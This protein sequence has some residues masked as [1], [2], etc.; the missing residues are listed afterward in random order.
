MQQNLTP[1]MRQY[2][3]LKEKY[4]D[5][6]LFFRLGDFYE[7]FFDDAETASREL[8]LVLTG[9]NCGLEQ[10]A[11]M[12]GVPY[13]AVD[14]YVSRLIAKGYKVAICEQ[15]TDPSLSE[16]LVVRDVIRVITP[17]TIIEESMLN[18]HKNNYIVS[19]CA[20]S[21]GVGIAYSDVSTGS[22]FVCEIAEKKWAAKLMDELSRINATE[23]IANE[24]LLKNEA[25]T[26]RIKR[27]YY[28]E[29]Y[30]APY[31]FDQKRGYD[32]LTRHFGVASLAG[33]GCESMTLAISAAGALMGYLEET[34]KN[35]LEHIKKI[36]VNRSSEYMMLDASARRNLELTQP[37]SEEYGKRST[38]LYVL[39]KTNTAM[40]SRMLRSWIDQPLQSIEKI[41]ERLDAVESLVKDPIKRKLICEL[42]DGVY[43]IERVCSRIAYGT[44]NARDCISLKL[45]T[46]LLPKIAEQ[47][48]AFDTGL[49]SQ[50]KSTLDTLQDVYELLEK[51]IND[52][53]PISVKEG[54]IIKEGYNSEIDELRYAAHG[55]RE[56]L[57]QL[58]TQERENT[59]IKNLKIGFNRVFGYYFEVTKAYQH[60]VPYYFER[61][62]TLA[63]AER[64]ITPDLKAME[65][66]ILGAE[67]KS[68]S[69]EY[70]AFLEIRKILLDDIERL[71]ATAKSVATLD[72]LASL[73]VVADSYDYCKPAMNDE[74][75]ISIENGRHPV[76]EQGM[77]GGFVPNNTYLCDDSEHRLV[78]ITG[79]NMAGKST[80][81]RQVALIVLMAH[82]G[83]FVPASNADISI[84]D[85]IFTRVGASDNVSF[86]QSTFM[87]E[88]SE[89]ANILNNATSR[90][91]LI[92]DEIGRGTSTFDGLSIAW[93]VL[94][95]IA[96]QKLLGAKT[97]FATHYHELAELEGR[98]DGVINYRMAVKEMGDDI[99]FLRKVVRGGA[100]R[101]F[102]IQVARLAGLPK[103][104]INRAKNI[105]A[106][107]EASG[108]KHEQELGI[109]AAKQLDMFVAYDAAKLIEEIQQIDIDSLTPMQALNTLYEL[110]VKSKMKG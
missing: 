90:S 21:S 16:G 88:M 104:V 62:Q 75:R 52:A 33:F 27:Q 17:G 100:D 105:L 106:E 51:S 41:Q 29:C 49:F 107:L 71:Q 3:E 46:L 34:Q 87:V 92:L 78:I 80:Y 109:P 70:D 36:S 28:L 19:L 44:L 13:H 25:L 66:K 6:L 32:K 53:P 37:I 22:F 54:G 48:S 77:K 45:S 73:A 81:M 61:K 98:L 35:S 2:L 11:P 26:Q 101:S 97:L 108:Q 83:S 5:C 55:G 20:H 60:L 30:K 89:V 1:M 47:I 18:E 68:I 40:G 72:A 9:R 24:N 8:E 103:R 67:E 63:N 42:L 59:G 56:W 57:M 110:Q 69:L 10:R 79:P 50:I 43:D 39:D 82:I 91:L 65:D 96:D 4:S 12:C 31:A 76:V 93:A 85:R 95:Y 64:Y 94:E 38:L 84:V 15:L 23:I 102:G 7:M 58:E 14:S 86:G 74:G 99:V